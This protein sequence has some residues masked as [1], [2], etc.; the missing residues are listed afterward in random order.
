MRTEEGLDFASEL[1]HTATSWLLAFKVPLAFGRQLAVNEIWTRNRTEPGIFAVNGPPGTGRRHSCVMWWPQSSPMGESTRLNWRLCVQSQRR[2]QIRC[3]LIPLSLTVHA[4]GAIVITSD[5]GAVEI[6]LSSPGW[7]RYRRVSD[8][9][10]YFGGLATVILTGLA[11]TWRQDG[12]SNDESSSLTHCGGKSAESEKGDEAPRRSFR[13]NVEG[14]QCHLIYCDRR[15][16]REPA[17]A[18]TR[19]SHV[20][21]RHRRWE[22]SV[23]TGSRFRANA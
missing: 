5:H 13:P 15:K 22:P 21:N 11:G 23:A 18:P 8:R 1:S 14:A 17:L 7:K 2:P 6:P 12:Q 4:G 16:V 10:D 3:T 20:L 9:S 19:L